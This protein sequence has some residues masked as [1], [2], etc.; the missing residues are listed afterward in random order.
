MLEI[1]KYNQYPS[2]P[3][4]H[5]LVKT[6]FPDLLSDD[7]LIVLSISVTSTQINVKELSSFFDLIYRIDGQLSELGYLLLPVF[8][9]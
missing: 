7:F 3:Q 9:S 1:E 6:I 4:K 8:L 2:P 5:L